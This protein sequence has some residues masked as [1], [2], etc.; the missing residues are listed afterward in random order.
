MPH[1]VDEIIK[2]VVADTCSVWNVLSS[3]LLHRTCNAASFD[4]AI[5]GFVLYE[6]LSKPRKNML[7]SADSE[8]KRRLREARKAGQFKSYDLELEDLQEV[9]LLEARKRL[10]KGELSAVAF[11]KRV[12]I[13]LQTDDQGA[14]KLATAVLTE[15]KVQT[16]PHVL[17]WLFFH[18]HL[19]DG[20][21]PSIQEEHARMDRPL[22][23]FFHD[24]Y[25]EA[26]RCRA[27][28][29]AMAPSDTAET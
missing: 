17:G 15:R 9:E 4:Y 27:M 2:T 8:L 22:R 28:Q 29:A 21:L 18:G 11:A 14:R 12:G 6:C 23:K 26:M 5:T 16:T 13:G 25:M 20:D 19:I 10:S 24:M 7:S 3:G 1:R